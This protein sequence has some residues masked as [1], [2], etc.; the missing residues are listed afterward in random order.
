VGFNIDEIVQ[1]WNDMYEAKMWQTG[2]PSFRLEPLL[3]RR[4]SKIFQALEHA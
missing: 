1:A 2:V 3:Q 4:V